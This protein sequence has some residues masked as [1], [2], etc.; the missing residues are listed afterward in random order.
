MNAA[1]PPALDNHPT[2]SIAE[3]ISQARSAIEALALAADRE[4]GAVT[5]IAVSKK[6]PEA[7]IREAYTAGQRHFGENYLNEAEPKL[8]A[9][10]DLPLI[11]HF[12]GRIQ[13]NKT[14]SLA[15]HFDW[16][17]TVDRLKIAQRLSDARARDP[18]AV[19][20]NLCLQV[21]IDDDPNKG[22]V[23][24]A[25]V[26]ALADDIVNLPGLRLRGLMTI[27]DPERA[28]AEG[29]ASLQTLFDK[30]APDYG[31]DTLSMGMSG[32]YDAAIRH[33]ATQVRLGTA[34][35]GPR[36]P[37][38]PNAPETIPAKGNP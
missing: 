21:N 30:L 19:P 17:H 16:V 33:G 1:Q 24:A 25:G 14:R 5:L 28:P 9:L 4:P 20:L 6:Q 37:A 13:S 11:W 32:D 29:F 15:Q 23:A 36:P 26:R 12:I 27:L 7:A 2:A 35:F 18:G 10:H 38:T 31:W 3:R 8:A 34:L 22:G